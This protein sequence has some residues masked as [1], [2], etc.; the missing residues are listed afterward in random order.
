MKAGTFPQRNALVAT[1]YAHDTME[2]RS[3][4]ARLWIKAATL[5]GIVQPSHILLKDRTIVF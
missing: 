2:S 1:A 3:G 4:A 5:A